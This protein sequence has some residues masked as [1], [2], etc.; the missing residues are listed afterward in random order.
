MNFDPELFFRHPPSD[1]HS[2][3]LVIEGKSTH[4]IFLGLLSILKKGVHVRNSRG[5]VLNLEYVSEGE[6]S[7]LRRYFN[8]IGIELKWNWTRSDEESHST[9][10]AGRLSS[11]KIGVHLH[12]KSLQIY[13]DYLKLPG[14][15][16]CYSL[17]F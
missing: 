16:D 2:I 10:D 5:G 17:S 11:Y 7:I 9:E 15:N 6:L 14:V 1:P 8:S 12:E 13:F 4:H 3:N